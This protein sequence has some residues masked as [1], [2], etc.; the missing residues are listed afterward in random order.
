MRKGSSQLIIGQK[1]IRKDAACLI[2]LGVFPIV[3]YLLLIGSIFPTF[4]FGGALSKFE[5]QVKKGI[6]V[7]RL[8]SHVRS[9]AETL[10][11][12]KLQN[13]SPYCYRQYKKSAMV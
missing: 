5:F 11:C 10:T 3:A 1:C 13:R 8:T 6:F 12:Q 4:S 7:L 2:K 9:R